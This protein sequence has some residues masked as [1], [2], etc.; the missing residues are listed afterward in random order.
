MNRRLAVL[1]LLSI[2]VICLLQLPAQAQ[3]SMCRT[4]LENSPEGRGMSASF[5]R[6]ILFLLGIPY[7]LFGTFGILVYRGYRKKKA[8]TVRP[9]NPYIPVPGNAPDASAMR[10]PY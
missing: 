2:V 3:C 6:G 8:A 7:L 4:A 10:R 1:A 5:N 9:A